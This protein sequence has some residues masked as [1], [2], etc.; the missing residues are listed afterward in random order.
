M[1]RGWRCSPS[2]SSHEGRFGVHLALKSVE[3]QTCHGVGEQIFHFSA[4]FFIPGVNLDVLLWHFCC[5]GLF[6][7][8]FY[9]PLAEVLQLVHFPDYNLEV[10]T[11]FS[12]LR[13]LISAG[14]HRR[15]LWNGRTVSSFGLSVSWWIPTQTL[16]GKNLSSAVMEELKVRDYLTTCLSLGT[17]TLWREI[18]V[19]KQII[20]LTPV[21][22]LGSAVV[23]KSCWTSL[24]IIWK[25]QSMSLAVPK[26]YSSALFRIQLSRKK[27]EFL[28]QTLMKSSLWFSDK[29]WVCFRTRNKY[30]VGVSLF[31]F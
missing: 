27:R 28:R 16:P 11:E 25:P 17:F 10:D 19:I 30:F 15:S 6:G 22:P 14:F 12:W 1:L 26:T 4:L 24:Q 13:L 3:E 7:C 9:E 18:P 2:P 23:A 29:S 8:L 5:L 31:F 21:L 20:P